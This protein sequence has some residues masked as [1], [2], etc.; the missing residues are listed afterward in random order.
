MLYEVIT[1]RWLN[2]FGQKELMRLC[3]AINSIPPLTIRT[4]TLKTK[5]RQLI[6]ALEQTV[7]RIEPTPFAPEGISLF[8]P[9]QPISDFGAFKDG[10]FQVQDEAAQLV[11]LLRN[12]FV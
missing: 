8:S 5:R 1:R 12:N 9:H 3:D 10:W 2:R 4:N 7:E 11:S 6:S